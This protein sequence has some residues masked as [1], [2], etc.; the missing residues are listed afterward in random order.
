MDRALEAAIRLFTRAFDEAGV[1][2][3]Y[4]GL[5]G[6]PVP[7]NVSGIVARSTT[8]TTDDGSER[9]LTLATTSNFQQFNFA[10]HCRLFLVLNATAICESPPA[11]H[12]LATIAPG[13]LPGPLVDAW[14]MRKW[15]HFMPSAID[16]L[17]G[18]VAA[19]EQY[20]RQV[21][22]KLAEVISA[23][24]PDWRE[25]IGLRD[26]YMQFADGFAVGMGLPLTAEV[27][28]MNG[29]PMTTEVSGH[30]KVHLAQMQARGLSFR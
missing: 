19:Q 14:L 24:P 4:L 13:Q 7:E 23:T 28:R 29:L 30:L 22:T 27:L 2:C 20:F 18:G 15:L 1:D 26:R 17:K 9:Y 5:R 11:A 12:M 21:G 8:Y 16:T 3:G 10:P 25:A 6:E